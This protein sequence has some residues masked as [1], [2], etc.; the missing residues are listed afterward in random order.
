[1][2][3]TS[4]ILRSQAHFLKY[5]PNMLT[6]CNSLCGFAAILY[7]I[8][9]YKA[10][11]AEALDIFC[12]AAWVIFF[13]MIFDV[14]DGLAARLLNAASLHGIQMDSLSD[15]VTFGVTPAI[16]TALFFECC[17]DW[18][19]VR[20]MR[21]LSYLLCSVY[22]GGAALRLA[23]YNVHATLKTKKNSDRFSGLPSPGAAAALCVSVLFL[24]KRFGD[25][26]LMLQKFGIYLAIFAAFLGLLMTSTI[27]YI[28]AG[29]WLMSIRRNRKKLPIVLIAV[30]ILVCFR[31]DGLA[32]L[33]ALY[34]ASGP[35]LMLFELGQKKKVENSEV[36]Q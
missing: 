21:V 35:I 12:V 8:H 27:P 14:F 9:S 25:N 32:F 11:P 3:K 26:D 4:T 1:M 18:N 6:L 13:A 7:M 16:M 19:P 33:A 2:K 29:K 15:M 31:M 28:H 23:T 36:E 22:M 34:I 20:W 10:T 17:Y 5:I 30:A 24:E